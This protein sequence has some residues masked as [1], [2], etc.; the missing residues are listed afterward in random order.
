M[1]SKLVTLRFLTAKQVR[2]L[3][4]MNI[5]NASPT[6]PEMLESATASPINDKLQL[7]GGTLVD[8]SLGPRMDVYRLLWSQIW[9][10]LHLVT[11][12]QVALGRLQTLKIECIH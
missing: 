7:L 11:Y 4:R 12:T 8:G 9:I 1:A 3:Y 10:F 6:Q 5:M 2:T